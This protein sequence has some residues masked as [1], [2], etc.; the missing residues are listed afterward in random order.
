MKQHGLPC[1]SKRSGCE[2]D[3]KN[4]CK[5]GIAQGKSEGHCGREPSDTDGCLGQQEKGEEK[6]EE[7]GGALAIYAVSS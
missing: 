3:D 6:G 4:E 1:G 7:R 5:E 2:T